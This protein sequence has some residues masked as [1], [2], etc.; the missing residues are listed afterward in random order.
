MGGNVGRVWIE[1]KGELSLVLRVV[2]MPRM[3]MLSV[4]DSFWMCLE[5]SRFLSLG[6]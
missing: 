5:P 3:V 1:G 6:N 4:L 2:Q